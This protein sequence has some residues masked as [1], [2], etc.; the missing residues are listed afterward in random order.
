MRIIPGVVE[1]F[2]QLEDLPRNYLAH[3]LLNANWAVFHSAD[4]SR[5]LAQAKL[6]FVASANVAD[7]LDLL[8]LTDRQQHLL[9]QVRDPA[10]KES[11][12]DLIVNQSFRRD[13][14]IKGEAR[15]AANASERWL[16][17]RFALSARAEDIPLTVKGMLAEAALTPETYGVLLERLDKGPA[18]ARQLI[19]EPKIAALGLANLRQHLLVLVAQRTCQI[20]L[21]AAGEDA[22]KSRTDAFNRA[23][24]AQARVGSD[25][26]FLASPVTGAG[27]A[28]DRIGQLALLALLEGASDPLAFIW[29]LL[30]DEPTSTPDGSERRT[31]G[32]ARLARDLCRQDTASLA[33]LE[34]I[35]LNFSLLQYPRAGST[36]SSIGSPRT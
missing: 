23:V 21:P 18:T 13:I 29:S 10:R 33:R 14:Y 1:R 32:P 27:V 5:D 7:H 3:E 4:V 30:K 2:K 22:R 28:V 19:A 11:L 36:R 6:Q 31:H 25:Y 16:D 35:L 9:N 17:L 24:T 8:N 20:A 15:V 34:E 26:G 12:R